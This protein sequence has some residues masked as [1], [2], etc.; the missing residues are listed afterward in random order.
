M[1]FTLWFGPFPV[2]W[3]ARFDQVSERGFI[4]R[5][6]SGPFRRWEH[7]HTF[8]PVDEL[9]T[10]VSD[11]IVLALRPH[12]FWGFF[13]LGMRLSLPLLFFYRQWRTRKHLEGVP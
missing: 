12:L 6:A 5:Q 3:Q 2:R 10:R 9:R 8:T 11:E 1:D 7:R 4:D 13:G